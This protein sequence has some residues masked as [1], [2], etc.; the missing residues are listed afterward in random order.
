MES[1]RI[2]EVGSG[3]DEQVAVDARDAKREMGKGR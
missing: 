1:S 3:N 2:I